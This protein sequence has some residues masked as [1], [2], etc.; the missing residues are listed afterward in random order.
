MKKTLIF[1]LVAVALVLTGCKK[2]KKGG[3]KGFTI[4]QGASITLVQGE[5]IRL[6][7]TVDGNVSPEYTFVSADPTKV[8]VDE[9][10]V[11]AAYDITSAPVV[12]TVTA[13]AAVNN[14][15]VS[16]TQTIAVSVVDFASSLKFHDFYLMQPSEDWESGKYA[17]YTKRRNRA[18]EVTDG[19]DATV[20]TTRIEGNRDKLDSVFPKYNEWVHLYDTVVD[21]ETLQIGLFQDS[22]ERYRAWI[23]SSDCFFD[24]DGYF[25]CASQGAVLETFFAFM[26]D[27]KYAYVLGEREFIED[28]TA[29]DSIRPDGV[30]AMPFPGYFQAG[31]LDEEQ[32]LE[33][34]T[35]LLTTEEGQEGPSIDDYTFWNMYD[36]KIVPVQVDVDE[37]GNASTYTLPLMGYPTAGVIELNSGT[38]DAW[39]QTDNYTFDATVY[40]NPMVGY[41]L[42][43][44]TKVDPETGE[45]YLGYAFDDQGNL[46]MSEAQTIRYSSGAAAAPK[47]VNH[48]PEHERMGAVRNSALKVQMNVTKTLGAIFRMAH[49][50]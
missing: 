27:S 13:S 31:H 41:C 15:K 44:E 14:E 12:V 25:Q 28:V 21:G 39:L 1:C 50:R 8:F 29:L 19:D 43:L 17:I 9:T 34:F 30:E 36:S 7:M 38:G 24:A 10:G 32:Y 47:K 18:A 11:V 26:Q 3:F 46:M 49:Q 45:E 2:D 42:K 16:Y 35:Q 23:L 4:N 33:F 20:R 48:T 22:V 40:G 6:S 37:E 5:S